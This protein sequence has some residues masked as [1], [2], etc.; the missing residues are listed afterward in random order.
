MIDE[1]YIPYIQRMMSQRGAKSMRNVNSLS[2]IFINCYVPGL[3]LRINNIKT[4]LRLSE[5][6]TLYAICHKNAGVIRKE[7]AINTR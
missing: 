5:N 2:L 3:T 4:S 1:E 6:I 7:T